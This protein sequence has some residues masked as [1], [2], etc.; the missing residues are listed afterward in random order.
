MSRLWKKHREICI[1][2]CVL[3]VLCIVFVKIGSSKAKNS[4]SEAP[5]THIV[6]KK[7][8][9]KRL[10]ADEAK[11][12]ILIEEKTKKQAE[13]QHLVKELNSLK[14][15]KAKQEKEEAA[16]ERKTSQRQSKPENSTHHEST[17]RGDMN[18]AQTG[19]IIGNRNSH[20]YHVPG[21]AG[22]RINSANTVYFNNEQEAIDAGYRKAKR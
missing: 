5:K 14:T 16:Q 6:F 17:N 9:A 7:V 11:H 15:K 3:L 10:S 12:K 20:I 1:L 18:T 8:G 2:L 13:Y 4:S 22:Y 21:Q 19:R